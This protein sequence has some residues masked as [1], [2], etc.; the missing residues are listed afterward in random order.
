MRAGS[1]RDLDQ[2]SANGGAARNWAGRGQSADG[3]VGACVLPAN[4]GQ[5]TLASNSLEG[6]WGQPPIDQVGEDLFGD[7]AVKRCI[8]FG[9]TDLRDPR[10]FRSRV[11]GRQQS[12][13][14][15]PK[16]N[17][18]TKDTLPVT[19]SAVDPG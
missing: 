15:G 6:R 8:P 13:L 19:I 5:A 9:R 11:P 17:F 16:G 14:P 3:P 10:A 7:W 18:T 1:A 2:L 4:C 12:G